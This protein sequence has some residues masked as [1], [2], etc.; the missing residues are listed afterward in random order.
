MRHAE[1]RRTRRRM[2]TPLAPKA[3]FLPISISAITA[4][5]REIHTGNRTSTLSPPNGDSDS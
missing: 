5:P 3:R 4:A 1:S 2:S